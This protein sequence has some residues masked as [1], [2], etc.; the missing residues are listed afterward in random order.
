MIRKWLKRF[1][2]GIAVALVFAQF[3][4]YGRDHSNPSA[5][6]EPVWDSSRTRELARR[7][8]F[9]CHSNETIWPWYSHVAPVS[10]L[11]QSDVDEGRAT[12][13]FSEWNREYSEA[14]E[15][16]KEV[17]E[18]EMPMWAYTVTHA[19]ARL[20]NEEKAALMRGLDAT[21]GHSEVAK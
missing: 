13:N 15:A 6:I 18:N 4:P 5:R 10:W 9:D 14:K 17:E 21:L 12:M 7:A 19:E 1:F 8:C 3:V 11:L 16:S 20:S 2:I